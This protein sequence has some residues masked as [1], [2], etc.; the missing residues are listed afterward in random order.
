MAID[1]EKGGQG[2]DFVIELEDVMDDPLL[3]DQNEEIE[4]FK[5]ELKPASTIP[6]EFEDE[7]IEDDDAA[8]PQRSKPAAS[9][10][11][12]DGAPSAD[13]RA[14]AAEMRAREIEARALLREGEQEAKMLRWQK[15]QAD[16]SLGMVGEKIESFYQ[17]LAA[18]KDNGDTATELAIQRQINAAENIRAQIEQAKASYGD[19]DQLYRQYQEKARGIIEAPPPGTPVGAGITSSNPL[20]IQWSKV[21]P[22]MQSNKDAAK[23]VMAQ[24]KAMAAEGWQPDKP[25]FYAQLT[26]RVREQFPDLGAKALQAPKGKPQGNA[27]RAPV[28]PTRPSAADGRTPQNRNPSKFILTADEQRKMRSMKLDPKNKEHQREWALARLEEKRR[29]MM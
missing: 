3:P 23:F 7:E 29:G 16:I 5:A 21:N 27:R 10:D 1:G 25:G 8:P 20:A 17:Q 22:W 26:K 4:D 12:D 11:D 6:E 19:P 24:S 15:S 2:D 18:A 28:A 9:D 13:A 14:A